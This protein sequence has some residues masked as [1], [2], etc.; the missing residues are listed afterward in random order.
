MLFPAGLKSGREEAAAS[1][2]SSAGYGQCRKGRH[3]AHPTSCRA[4]VPSQQ[5]FIFMCSIIGSMAL[6]RRIAIGFATGIALNGK[7]VA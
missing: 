2:D 7:V 6:R 4:V 1:G 5:S 3:A